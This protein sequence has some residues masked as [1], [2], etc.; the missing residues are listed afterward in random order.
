MKT[1][2]EIKDALNQQIPAEAIHPAD[3]SRGIFG[4]YITAQY[5]QQKA[6]EVF[7]V[8][9]IYSYDIISDEQITTNDGDIVFIT[10]V[11]VGFV[12]MGDDGSSHF[13]SRPGRGVG[14]AQ[15]PFDRRE[16]RKVP[17]KPQQIDTAAK[18]SLSDAIKNALMRTG[19]YLGA[20]LY[21]DERMAQVM[22]YEAES[23]RGDSDEQR[24]S[25]PRRQPRQETDNTIM[26]WFGSAKPKDENVNWGKL[27]NNVGFHEMLANKMNPDGEIENFN[28]NHPRVINHFKRHFGVDSGAK[29][30][31]EMLQALYIY[32]TKGS[33]EAAFGWPEYYAGEHA[34]TEKSLEQEQ[35]QEQEEESKEA[36]MPPTISIG[37]KRNVSVPVSL[38]SKVKATLSDEHWRQLETEDIRKPDD[39]LWAV[40][41]PFDGEWTRK[42]T[43]LME[44]LIGTVS[45]G[46]ID[47]SDIEFLRL[48]WETGVES[49]T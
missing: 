29:L 26:M 20:Q 27:I 21:F 39:W 37:P 30:T 25:Q 35:V 11:S 7:G 32:C 1:L 33:E 49:N 2:Q 46:K 45:D 43:E 12:Y 19:Q 42:H 4:D 41:K 47:G 14:V 8:D 22:G 48:M 3:P 40:V 15:A 13:F 6:N 17:P 16:N 9:G 38:Q 28:P 44:K 18:S 24:E 10:T 36:D 31:W 5:A 23:A 34:P